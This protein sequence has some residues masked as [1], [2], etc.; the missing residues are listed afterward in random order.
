MKRSIVVILF[1]FTSVSI[2]RAQ[3]FSLLEKYFIHLEQHD[4]FMGSVMVMQ[5]DTI[6]FNESYGYLE[7]TFQ[8]ALNE[9]TKYRIG[10]ISKVFTSVLILQAQEKG[11]IDIQ[12]SI[13]AYFPKIDQAE[14][15]TIKHLL[16][17]T[18]GIDNITAQSDYL[19]WYFF[20]QTRSELL[21]RISVLPVLFTPGSKVSYSNS[22]YILLSILLEK[23]YNKTFEN[24]LKDYLTQPKGWESIHAGQA[25]NPYENE[26]YSFNY[27]GKWVKAVETDA[28]IPLGAG[29][30]TSNIKD[31][32]SF[33]H[34]LFNNQILSEESI[35]LMTTTF[36]NMGLGIFP[37][38]YNVEQ[39][40]GHTGSIDGFSSIV[41]TFPE[42]NL[43][44]AILSN[45]LHYNMN[46]ISL[47]L[48]DVI[49][50]KDIEIPHFVSAEVDIK[51]LEKYVGSYSSEMIPLKIEITLQEDQLY[52]QATDQSAF[53][54]TPLSN[55]VFEFQLAGV[56]IIFNEQENTFI[57]EQG[58]MNIQFSKE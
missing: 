29:A 37:L 14:N 38:S 57:L 20:P 3:N 25:I 12:Q 7:E 6:I 5:G 4:K 16:N 32:V 31:L 21:N 23:I 48:L 40:W 54:L 46:E 35:Q 52:A 39:A 1:M 44:F 43:T 50:E 58:G 55:E 26:A 41:A 27:E 9:D 2:L 36:Q 34:Q 45:A 47:T 15:I 13:E 8:K 18:S 30:I 33:M 24:I 42:R 17:H 11:L 28:S 53:P 56:K 10:S 49:H 22:N 51:I 19:N